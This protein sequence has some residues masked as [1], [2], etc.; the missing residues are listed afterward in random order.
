GDGVGTYDV[1]STFTVTIYQ[2]CLCT[3]TIPDG[4]GSGPGSLGTATHDANIFATGDYVIP[5]IPF[6]F[7][8][9]SFRLSEPCDASDRVRYRGKRAV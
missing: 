7:A 5:A 6:T 4:R 9:N 2:P 1:M 8:P 3:A